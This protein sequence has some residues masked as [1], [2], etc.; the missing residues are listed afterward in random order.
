MREISGK[1]FGAALLAGLVTA[2]AAAAAADEGSVPAAESYAY[3]WPIEPSASADF[4]ELELP[5]EVYRSVTDPSLRDIGVYNAQGEPVP[6]LISA[7]ANPEAAPDESVGLAPLPVH[8]PSGTP[9]SEMRFALE[10]SDDGTSMRIEGGV[11]AS[12]AQ[13]LELLAYVADLGEPTDRLRALD[14][15]WP[16]AIEPLI[17]HVTIE[18]SVDLDQWSMM[19]GGT[20]AGLRQDEANIERRRVEVEPRNVRYLRLSWRSVP[21][22]WRITK[23]TARYSQAAPEAK[24]GWITLSPTGRDDKDRGYLY[25]V[26]GWPM[27]DRLGLDLSAQNSLVRAG[28]DCWLQDEKRWQPVHNGLFYRLRR[29]GNAL[30]SEPV[31]IAARRCA[32]WKVVVERGDAESNPGL[33]LGWRPDRVL[34]IAQGEGPWQLVAGSARDAENDFPQARRYSDPEM[35]KLLRDAGPVGSASLGVRR[36]L[37]GAPSLEPPRNPEWRRWLLWLGLA[38]GVLLVGGMAW[39]LSRY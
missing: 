24:R 13:A 39:R 36:E 18:G 32:R 31:A 1:R 15:E 14:I 34:F 35:R 9:V 27:V 17:T 12:D 11:P 16:R 8:A 20:I 5:L 33:M 26:G 29:D 4:Y 30:V 37:G 2:A 38:A 7:P 19:G 3:G 23:L 6:R 28:I 21:D 25:E 10:R 22:A